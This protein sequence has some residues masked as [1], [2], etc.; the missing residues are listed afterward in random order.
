MSKQL[1]DDD[2]RQSLRD[3]CAAKGVEVHAKFGPH[4]GWVELNQ[5][6]QDRKLVRYPCRIAF[7][8]LPLQAGEFA[9]PEPLGPRPDDGFRICV[10]PHFE[11]DLEAVPAL[12]LY[13]LVAVN[14]GDF[15]TPEDAE[16]F[17]AAALGMSRE[18]Y[19]QRL[20]QF[21]DQVSAEIRAGAPPPELCR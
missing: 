19:Y 13:Q 11:A 5:L 2:A 9:Y 6:L 21:A 4:L 14:Y 1:T 8:S 18:E 7:D 3:H 17:G 12:V 20:C 16:A 10:H 15:A